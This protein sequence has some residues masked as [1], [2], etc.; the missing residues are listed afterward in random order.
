LA[1]TIWIVVPLSSIELR[2]TS[3]RDVTADRLGTRNTSL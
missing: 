1:T 2:S 3:V